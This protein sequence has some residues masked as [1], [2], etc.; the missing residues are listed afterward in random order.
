[1]QP[2][3]EIDT[4]L[5]PTWLEIDL[6][7]VAHNCRE[8]RRLVG[9]STNIFAAL[10][11]NGYGCGAVPVARVLEREGVRGFAV[12]N[13]YDAVRLREAGIEAP[14]LLYAGCGPDVC[15]EVVRHRLIPSISSLKEA[16]A[17]AGAARKG[18]EVFVKVDVGL[19][20]AGVDVDL[21]APLV[22]A[23][24]GMPELHLG[25]VYTHLHLP[26]DLEDDSYPNWQ[27]ARF[28]RLIDALARDGIS[29]PVR[30]VASTP[31]V[32]QFPGM[33]LNAVDPGRLLYGIMHSV[34]PIQHAELRHAL[35]ALKTRLILRKEVCAR[36]QYAAYSPVLS[37]PDGILGLI[38]IGWG[39]GYPRNV[40]RGAKALVRGRRVPIL[41]GVSLEHMRLDLTD[42]P[43][44]VVGD[45]VVLIGH[46]EGCAITPEEIAKEWGL[47]LTELYC[48]M[49]DHL[50]RIYHSTLPG[51]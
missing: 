9:A 19:A 48:G 50:P 31:V 13:A 32:L 39:D 47:G 27:F 10:K 15:R 2:A 37:R 22:R 38:P 33:Y 1:M 20:R 14:I 24:I 44:A 28:N 26:P 11:R 3:T 25:G 35:R 36:T 5:R 17:Y 23:I 6:D 46:Q 41:D 45:E 21:A 4:L 29:I 12:A 42:V 49:R 18:F 40:P 34:G 30:M 7:A 43:E 16:R 8:L 51:L